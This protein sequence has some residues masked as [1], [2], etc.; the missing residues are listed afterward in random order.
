MSVDSGK[1][2]THPATRLVQNSLQDRVSYRRAEAARCVIPPAAEDARAFSRRFRCPP[3]ISCP[4]RLQPRCGA[5]T[6]RPGP[7]RAQ[8][9]ASGGGLPRP[10]EQGRGLRSAGD[11]REGFRRG[12][13]RGAQPGSLARN[14]AFSS[15]VPPL[16]S[17]PRSSGKLSVST[18]APVR[19]MGPSG[20]H[21]HM[22]AQ[23]SRVRW[24]RGGDAA[25]G[26]CQFRRPV[27]GGPA[28][29]GRL[30]GDLVWAV[31]AHL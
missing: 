18:P 7:A 14:D 17:P 28:C 12:G 3:R 4:A 26:G 9:E 30:L 15:P 25:D 1:S 20:C 24:M 19:V 23:P 2:R 8:W 5:D 31:Q 16:R 13:S 11:H 29:A 22:P 6:V 27:T 10:G 21:V